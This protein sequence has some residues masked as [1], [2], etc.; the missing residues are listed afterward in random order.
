M[1]SK[2]LNMAKK[3]YYEVLGVGKNASPEEIKK[4]YRLLAKEYHPDKNQGSEEATDK[5]KEISE[6]YEVLSNSDKKSNYDRFGHGNNRENQNPFYEYF[7]RRHKPEIVGE[8]I[9]ILIKLTLEEIYSGVKKTY[10][11]NRNDSC[12]TCLGK[13]GLDSTEC[14]TCQGNGSII[15]TIKTSVGTFQNQTTCHDCNGSGETYKTAC[16]SCSG[17]GLQSIE[18][19]VDVDIPSGVENNNMFVVQGKGNSVKNGRA[20]DLI[21][22]VVEKQHKVFTRIKNDLKMNLSLSYSQ[23]VLGDKVEIETIDGGKIRVNI[24]EYSDV[25]TN[26]RVPTKGLKQFKENNRGD[27]IITL[28]INIPKELDEKT[29]ELILALK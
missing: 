2:I 10:T 13:G 4:A 7:R 20:G 28:S 29:K 24:P 3:D 6:A 5:F 21:L 11:Y 8:T 17:S 1:E 19:T 25:G 27:L 16:E 26:L 12:N 15:S 23:L 9:S 18:E 22:K 14:P